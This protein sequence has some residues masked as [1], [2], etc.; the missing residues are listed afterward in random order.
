MAVPGFQEF[1]LPLLRRL[2]D[3]HEHRLKDLR[4]IVAKDLSLTDADRAEVLPSG[5]QTRYAN[6]FYWASIHLIRAKLT[7]SPSRGIVR[8]SSRGKEL[9][10]RDPKRIDLRLLSEYPNSWSFV[11]GETNQVL[12]RRARP[13]ERRRRKN[14]LRKATRKSV[15]RSQPICSTA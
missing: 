5:N 8:I 1:M 4:E 9:L 12:E 15:R 6:R 11:K 3:G 13:K 14:A 10:A 7:E 2:A